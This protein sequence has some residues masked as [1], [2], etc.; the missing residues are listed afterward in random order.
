MDLALPIRG[1][2]VLADETAFLLFVAPPL[3]SFGAAVCHFQLVA[4]EVHS[5]RTAQ[6]F[7]VTS[8]SLGLACA[9]MGTAAGWAWLAA[10]VALAVL[11]I[12]ERAP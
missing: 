8:S 11:E 4:V 5:G 6:L 12:V 1:G 7:R 2:A 10:A 3:A 9:R